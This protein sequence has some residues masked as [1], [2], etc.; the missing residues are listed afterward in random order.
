MELIGTDSLYVVFRIPKASSNLPYIHDI[1][2]HSLANLDSTACSRR[3]VAFPSPFPSPAPAPML[4]LLL[5]LLLL[6][7][8][9]HR[10]YDRL[11]NFVSLLKYRAYVLRAR[12]LQERW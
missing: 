11:Q 3:G 1:W 2:M 4:L 5:L 6:L 8:F 10:C 9:T 7:Q 12:P